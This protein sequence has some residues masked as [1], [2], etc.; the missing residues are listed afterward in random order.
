MR[1]EAISMSDTK[2]RDK[3]DGNGVKF[4]NKIGVTILSDTKYRDKADGSFLC[5]NGSHNDLS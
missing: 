4:K 5:L 2:Y 1:A 3:A